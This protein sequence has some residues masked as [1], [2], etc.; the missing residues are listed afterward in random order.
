MRKKMSDQGRIIREGRR[1]AKEIA[2]EGENDERDGKHSPR[3]GEL[4]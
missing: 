2:A 3:Q 1:I 4:F